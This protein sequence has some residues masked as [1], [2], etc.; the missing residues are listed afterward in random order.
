MDSILAYHIG[1][2]AMWYL[3][4]SHIGVNGSKAVHR[5]LSGDAPFRSA[6]L[7]KAH[8]HSLSDFK[9]S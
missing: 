1:H 2:M 5:Q 3:L 6:H 4:L 8:I 9:G 7:V